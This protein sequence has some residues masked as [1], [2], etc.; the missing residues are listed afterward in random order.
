[1]PLSA[2]IPPAPWSRK[3]KTPQRLDSQFLHLYL[4]GWHMRWRFV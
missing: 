3:Y 2:A 4:A 1:L